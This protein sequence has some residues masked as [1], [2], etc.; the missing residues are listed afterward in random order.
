MSRKVF[1][2]MLYFF[3]SLPNGYVDLHDMQTEIFPGFFV[4]IL[5]IMAFSS[6]RSKIQYLNLL[7][8]VIS[9]LSYVTIIQTV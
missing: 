3:L 4:I 9:N 6:R 7:D 8:N 2:K 5:M 1:L